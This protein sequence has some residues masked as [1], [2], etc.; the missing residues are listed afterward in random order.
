MDS[1]FIRDRFEQI[2][3][4]RKISV[5]WLSEAIGLNRYFINKI[6]RGE[7]KSDIDRTRLKALIEKLG[8]TEEAF[9]KGSDIAVAKPVTTGRIPFYGEIPAGNPTWFEGTTNPEAWIEPPP[10]C[11]T[12]KL[13]AL[14]VR[15][16]SMAPR[17]LQGDVLYLEPLSIHMGVKDP[18]R[19]V[20]RLTFERLNNRVVAAMVD[21]ESTLKQLKI[22]P[23]GKSK[24]NYELHLMPLNPEYTP[25]VIGPDSTADFQGVVVRSVRDEP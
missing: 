24:D 8:Y 12:T 13:F 10:F 21:G 2:S 5:R 25:I 14:R 9:F 6:M 4:E 17:F 18:E 20:P 16:Q 22:V 11:S 15:G 7:V 19:P 3:K 23:M 1:K